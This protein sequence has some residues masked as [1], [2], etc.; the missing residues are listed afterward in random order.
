[1]DSKITHAVEILK[2]GGVI[3]LPTETVYG[4]AADA[5]SKSA[6]DKIF[7]LKKRDGNKPLQVMVASIEQAEKIAHFNDKARE[8]A[9]KHWPG[10]LTI[11]LK[12][13][14]DGIANYFNRAGDTV[15]IRIPNHPIALE[16][17][18]ELNSPIAASSANISG[19]D[20]NI[21]FATASKTLGDKLDHLIDGG[22][23]TIGISS[24]VIDATD[25]ANIK[26][27]REGSVKI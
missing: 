1:M 15:G 9:R 7:E 8:L 27:I 3:L 22:K 25:G 10:A 17:I 2:A 26:I 4:I 24:T 6:I 5:R 21:D 12:L 14:S 13:R 18:R 11:V 16:I 23:S 20:P 19:E